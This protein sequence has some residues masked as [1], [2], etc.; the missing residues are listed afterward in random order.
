[1]VYFN[2]ALRGS[3]SL[4][5]AMIWAGMLPVDFLGGQRRE[6]LHIEEVVAAAVV[7]A[8]VARAVVIGMARSE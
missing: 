5:R 7:A 3:A 4:A 2:S 8:G 6:V 1:M